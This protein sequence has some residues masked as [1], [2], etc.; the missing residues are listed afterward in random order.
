MKG[1]NDDDEKKLD[2]YNLMSIAD[3][4]IDGEQYSEAVAVL[5]QILHL[6]PANSTLIKKSARM[7]AEI[8]LV[9]GDQSVNAIQLLC[10]SRVP[11]VEWLGTM[12]IAAKMLDQHASRVGDVVLDLSD[13]RGALLVKS[14]KWCMACNSEK[15]ASGADCQACSGC[16]IAH[17]C[18]SEHQKT[19]WIL[20]KYSCTAN[21]YR[22]QDLWNDTFFYEEQLE[23]INQMIS[24]VLVSGK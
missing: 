6:A 8:M 11:P 4:F 5:V 16:G 13:K 15:Q 1:S 9:D 2:P 7:V 10:F 17:Y 22:H 18:C 14:D 24:E 3:K 20:H 12:G 23:K 21:K 19:D